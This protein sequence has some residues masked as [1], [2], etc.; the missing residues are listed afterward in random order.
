MHM[1]IHMY[2]NIHEESTMYMYESLVEHISHVHCTHTTVKIMVIFLRETNHS[3][4]RLHMYTI[5]YMYMGELM[6]ICVLQN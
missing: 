4:Y 6:Q 3:I 1:H 2:T 5:L